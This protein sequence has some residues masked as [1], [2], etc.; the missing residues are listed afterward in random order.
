M[1]DSAFYNIFKDELLNGE[2]ILWAGQPDPTVLFSKSDIFNIPFGIFW[3]GFSI[4]WEGAAI[5]AVLNPNADKAASWSF[6]FFGVPFVLIGI[7]LI[8]GRFFYKAWKKK[9]T[10]YAVTNMRV[11]VVKQSRRKDVQGAYLDAIPVVNKSIRRDGRG[12]IT[13][14]NSTTGGW[15]YEDAGLDFLGAYYTERAPAFRDIADAEKVCRLVIDS[16]KTREHT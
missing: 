1:V 4:V 11:L 12:T 13:F 14:G 10:Y 15:M 7:Y 16:R 9:R 2:E 8:A 6:P 5:K 3:M